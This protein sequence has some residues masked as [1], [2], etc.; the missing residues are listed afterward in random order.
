MQRPKIVFWPRILRVLLAKK[1][2]SNLSHPD[3]K[4]GG[5][6][7]T[8]TIQY[9]VVFSEEESGVRTKTGRSKAEIKQVK[10]LY[11]INLNNSV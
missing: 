6:V 9:E 5:E 11:E 10:M 4:R 3:S 2:C 1:V 7:V 8:E